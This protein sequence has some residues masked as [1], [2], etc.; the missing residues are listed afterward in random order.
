MT[1]TAVN[2]IH[3]DADTLFILRNPGAAFPPA[4]FEKSWPDAL[5]KYQTKISKSKEASVVPTKHESSL[6]QAKS[7]CSELRFGLSSALLF[8]TSYEF[9]DLLTENWN[10]QDPGSGYEWTLEGWNWDGEAFLI[11][12]TILHNRTRDVPRKIDL[13]MFAKIAV[14]VDWYECLEVMD[15]WVDTW[16]TNSDVSR[17]KPFYSRDLLLN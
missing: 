2:K 17:V 7:Q 16:V 6:V 1:V 12:M 8:A 15:L 4:K 9:K 14:L 13:E 5:P 11:L 10:P 3:P